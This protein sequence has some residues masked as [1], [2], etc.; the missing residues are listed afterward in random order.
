MG[1]IQQRPTTIR[2]KEA[3]RCVRIIGP[4]WKLKEI[5]DD[6]LTFN[7]EIIIC[8]IILQCTSSAVVA[9]VAC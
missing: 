3:K 2:N 4:H 5:Y 6:P 9:H 1:R 8:G 7:S